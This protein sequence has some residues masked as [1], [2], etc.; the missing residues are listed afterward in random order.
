VNA[1]QMTH[2]LK[3]K[4]TDIKKLNRQ[5]LSRELLSLFLWTHFVERYFESEA[6]TNV[7]QVQ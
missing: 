6:E 7:I 4:A 2:L 3:A 5:V 1:K